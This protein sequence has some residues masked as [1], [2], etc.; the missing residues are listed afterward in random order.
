M[1]YYEVFEFDETAFMLELDSIFEDVHYNALY[2]AMSRA[3]K[4]VW[5]DIKREKQ[6][7]SSGY[8]Y[9]IM[10][11]SLYTESVQAFIKVF[12]SGVNSADSS[13]NPY[14]EKYMKSSVFNKKRSSNMEVHYREETYETYD[15]KNDSRKIVT[16]KGS[17]RTGIMDNFPSSKPHIN[18]IEDIIKAYRESFMEGATNQ[19][20]FLGA[21]FSLGKYFKKTLKEI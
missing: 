16:A 8:G 12:G 9:K 4:E 11:D 10:I 1:A 21:E 13:I 15:W 3:D 2:D 20:K 19:I 7:D 6:Q 18:Y 14:L 5:K 17:G